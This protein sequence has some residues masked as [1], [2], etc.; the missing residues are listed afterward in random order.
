MRRKWFFLET[1]AATPLKS[2]PGPAETPAGTLAWYRLSR[3]DIDRLVR[4]LNSAYEVVGARLRNGRYTLDRITDP[5]ELALEFP[6]RVHS[7]KK[8]LFPNWEKLFRFRLGGKIML[9]AEKAAM[10]RVIFGMHPCDLHAVRILDDCLFEGEADS[11]YRAKRQATVLVGVDCEPDDYCFCTSLGTDRV[12]SGFDLFLHR[13][14]DGYLVRVGSLRG[15]QLLRRHLPELAPVDEPQL[16]SA[17]KACRRSI[18]FPVESLAPVLGE[19]YDHP[20]WKAIGDRCIGCGSC[21]L[22][23]PTCYCFNVQDRLDLNL[24]GG[25]R[26]RTWDSCQFDQFTRVSGGSDFRP[27][28]T[29]RQRHRFFRKYKYLW[30]KHQRTACVGCGRCSR[31]CLAGID[32]TEVLNSLFT[33]QATAELAPAP[34]VEYQPQMAELVH[35]EELTAREKLFRL[36]LPEAV[37]FRPGAFLQVSVFGVGEAPLTIASAPDP[38][39]RE[40]ELV[41]RAKGNLTRALHRLSVGAAIGVRG[42]FGNG[43]PVDEFVGR[44]VL[45]V[46]GGIGLVTLRSLLLAILARRQDFGRVMLLYGSRSV[47]TFL[48]RDD[49]K[50]WHLG[51]ELD[52]RFAVQQFNA[53]WGVTGGDI[54]H[55]FRDLDIVPSRAVAAVS[56]PAVMYRNVN[57]LLFGLGFSPDDVYLNLE[58]HMKCGLGKCGRCQI[59]DITVCQCGPIFPYSRIRHL[60]EAIER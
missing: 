34:G 2:R 25:E 16:P 48:F 14:D 36:R 44:D 57:P 27:D 52:C 39:S 40:I 32:N 13:S 56:G 4:S 21:N 54:T 55:L 5:A 17:G 9:E 30:E 23:C 33:E 37:D 41:V 19:V 46:A 53:R 38:E 3:A 59:N 1:R 10:P 24:R 20:V 6:P 12:D 29:D 28:Q 50:R 26:V 18:R 8:F 11:A 51:E 60:R 22:L 15:Q 35:V 42:P 47:D 58:R 31:E 49:L 7:P 45:L 43:F